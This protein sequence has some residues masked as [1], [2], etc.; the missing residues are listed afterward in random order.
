MRSFVDAL[1]ATGCP[2]RFIVEV[3]EEAFLHKNQFQSRV[4]PM[5]REVGA[6]ISIDDFGVGYS[7]LSALTEITADEVKVDRSFVS[8]I[9]QRPRS[10]SLLRAVESL[11]GA[12]GMNVIVE[13]VETHEELAY[14]EAATRVRYAQGFYFARPAFF[15]EIAEGAS[16]LV[17]LRAASA[18]REAPA[19]RTAQP[20]PARRSD[21][22]GA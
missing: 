3:T 4:L 5:L 11:G 16:A 21:S 15:D 10:Q 19:A 2:E 1:E 22:R 6:K 18:P 9:H 20:R 8:A 17:N 13:G 14:L 7:S 12:L